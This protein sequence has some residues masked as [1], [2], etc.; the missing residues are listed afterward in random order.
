MLSH[1]N[2]GPKIT[3]FRRLRNLTTICSNEH[4][5]R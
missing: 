5:V 3:I 4:T 1:T 2:R